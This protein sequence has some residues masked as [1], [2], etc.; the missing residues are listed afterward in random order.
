M[1]GVRVSDSGLQIQYSF[2]Q[3]S[4]YIPCVKSF[5]L[6]ITTINIKMQIR[7]HQCAQNIQ[8]DHLIIFIS[9]W[10]SNTSLP[11]YTSSF[12]QAY[13]TFRSITDSTQIGACQDVPFWKLQRT[14]RLNHLGCCN[15]KRSC[16]PSTCV[17]NQ[18]SLN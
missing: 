18:W 14:L 15:N 13:C 1:G 3:V 5:P 8:K 11:Y 10:N 16:R 7:N 12:P 2:D 6:F 9:T 17:S 4:N